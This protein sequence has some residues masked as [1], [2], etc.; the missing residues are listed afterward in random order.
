LYFG[1]DGDADRLAVWVKRADG[2]VM[3]VAPNDLGVLYGWM[4]VND[5]LKA[6]YPANGEPKMFFIDKTQPTTTGLDFLVKYGNALAQKLGKNVRFELKTTPVGS[7]HFADEY[8]NGSLL[9]GVEESGHIVIKDFFDDAVGQLHFLLRALALSGRSL[10]DTIFQAKDEVG[11]DFGV[12]LNGWVYE[13]VN[14][15]KNAAFDETFM[16]NFE[17]GTPDIAFQRLADALGERS[18]GIDKV[19]MTTV[20]PDYRTG[21]VTLTDYVTLRSAGKAPKIKPAEGMIVSFKNGE[22]VMIRVSG[23]EGLVRVYVEAE[24]KE[25]VKTSQKAVVQAFGVEIKFENAMTSTDEDAAYG[26]VPPAATLEELR[27]GIDMNAAQGLTASGDAVSLTFD[28]A[29]IANFKRGDFSGITPVIVNIAP[30]TNLQML[31]GN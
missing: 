25:A 1:I 29:M 16:A 11:R 24:S 2:T 6:D 28:Q 3:E 5:V 23:T 8:Q 7:K 4:L 21:S 9:I 19:S 20:S 22:W 14:P 30:V 10:N 27:G 18:A 15:N 17:K 12:N 31:L 13:R 26:E